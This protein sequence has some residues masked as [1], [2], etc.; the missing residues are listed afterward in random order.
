VGNAAIA[1][2]RTT[3]GAPFYNIDKVRKRVGNQPGDY[4][5][6]ES[7]IGTHVFEI[8]D[9]RIVTPTDTWVA[10]PV[11]LPENEVNRADLELDPSKSYLTLTSCHPRF[12]AR[13]RIVVLA[14]LIE[15]DAQAPED[16]PKSEGA[17]GDVEFEG[18]HDAP[19]AAQ[20]EEGLEGDISKR[21][22]TILT[23]TLVAIVGLLWWWAFRRYRHPVTW[24]AGVV[25]FLAFLFVFYVFLERLLPA[26]Y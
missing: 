14:Q 2:H 21:G 19:D 11:T 23:G 10:G 20:L 12:S 15:N 8:I 13:E 25:P 9:V 16:A 17:V 4:I 1:G 18:Q 3:Y 22:P 5:V 26:G 6:T 24:F 7:L